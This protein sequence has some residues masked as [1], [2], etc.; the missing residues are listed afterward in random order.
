MSGFLYFYRVDQFTLDVYKAKSSKRVKT[1]VVPYLVWYTIS[2]SYEFVYQV[3]QW[4]A[5]SYPIRFNLLGQLWCCYQWGEKSLN[6]FGQSMPMYG[7]ADLP[8]WFLRDLIVV[9][10]CT[11]IIYLLLRHLKGLLPIGMMLLYVTQLWTSVP[12]FSIHA[13]LF[14]TLGLYGC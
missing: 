4:H 13:F 3:Y 14:F 7:P 6:I 11:P 1:L 8:L 12:G 2:A 9:S 10:F 5:N